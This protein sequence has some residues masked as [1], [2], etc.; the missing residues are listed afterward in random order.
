MRTHPI[1]AVV[2]LALGSLAMGQTVTYDLGRPSWFDFQGCLAP[3]LC[4][5]I[6]ERGPMAGSF[7]LEYVGS[8]PHFDHYLVRRL[9]FTADVAQGA[10]DITG[11]GEYRIGGQLIMMNRLTLELR[12]D[13]GELF[14]YDSGLVPVTAMFPDIDLA[15]QATPICREITLDVA[16][17]ESPHNCYAD[18]NR[19]TG[20]GVLDIFDFLCFQH[21]F[22]SQREYACDCDT[23]GGTGVCD[24]FD[25]LCFQNAFVNGCR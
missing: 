6:H 9:R 8:D 22:V 11:Q 15:V 16:A 23:S 24:I 20:S 14:S 19:S 1:V 18:C 7:D 4:P 5:G 12:I 3:C 13:G 21:A 25:F 10:R 17:S 2:T